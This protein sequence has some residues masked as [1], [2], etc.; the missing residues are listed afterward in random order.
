[1]NYCPLNYVSH[2]G[3][4]AEMLLYRPKT[5]NMSAAWCIWQTRSAGW[6]YTLQYGHIL[7]RLTHS[8]REKRSSLPANL[9]VI[10][11]EQYLTQALLCTAI[12]VLK[13]HTEH[14]LRK[15][16]IDARKTLIRQL[17]RAINPTLLK[18]RKPLFSKYKLC[19]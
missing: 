7:L 8:E 19:L 2:C 9:I 13:L 12:F 4:H 6:C 11:F 1:M 17:Q 5:P 16:F 14:T 10:Y 15:L 3:A 18:L